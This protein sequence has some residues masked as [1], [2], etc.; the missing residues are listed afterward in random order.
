MDRKTAKALKVGERVRQARPDSRAEVPVGEC[1]TIAHRYSADA[2]CDEDGDLR[3]LWD[4]G[5]YNDEGFDDRH[6][7]GAW[8]YAKYREL[9]VVPPVDISSIDNIERFLEA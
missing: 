8:M 6:A 9:E 5:Q 2:A 1:G 3:V 4:N 7:E